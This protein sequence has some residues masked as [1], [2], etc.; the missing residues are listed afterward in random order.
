MFV[1]VD[2]NRDEEREELI[3][4]ELEA[5]VELILVEVDFLPD[6]ASCEAVELLTVLLPEPLVV[7]VKLWAVLAGITQDIKYPFPTSC[8]LESVHLAHADD[9]PY[10]PTPQVPL[11]APTYPGGQSQHD[12]LQFKLD[13]EQQLRQA[14]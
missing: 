11:T 7:V 8:S 12:H 2:F 5:E 6:V 10:V 13:H 3:V 1:E 4:E 14:W 9:D